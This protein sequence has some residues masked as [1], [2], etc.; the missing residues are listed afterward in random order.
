MWPGSAHPEP[1]RPTLEWF[2]QER[3]HTHV[4]CQNVDIRHVRTARD[5]TKLPRNSSL[6]TPLEV[7]LSPEQWRVRALS[8]ERPLL[9]WKPRAR[10]DLVFWQGAEARPPVEN[11]S[12]VAPAWLLMN[13]ATALGT[14][15]HG[16]P[17]CVSRTRTAASLPPTNAWILPL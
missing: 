12:S 15:K 4:L 1:F 2:L 13:A 10:E 17:C 16:W 9:A 7:F 14:W 8:S 11:W 5:Y 3:Q 6:A